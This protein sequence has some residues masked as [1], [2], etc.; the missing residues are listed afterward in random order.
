MNCGGTVRVFIEVYKSR[1]ELVM[2]GAGHVGYALSKLADFMEFPYSIVDD[3]PAYCTRERFPKAANL[4]VHEDIEKAII[5]AGLNEKSYV[6][7][8]SKDG[9]D[10]VLKTALNYPCAYVGMIASK[11]KVINIFKKLLSEGVAQERLD[12]VH[13]PIGIEIGAETTEE[14]AI[15]IMGEII[16]VSKEGPTA[17]ERGESSLVSIGRSSEDCRT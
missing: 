12:F 6:M 11:R 8:I 17:M 7:I 2:V 3:R 14:I 9:D 4:F 10:I 16:K 15:S 1:P 5:E 13:T